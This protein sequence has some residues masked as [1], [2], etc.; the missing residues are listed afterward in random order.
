MIRK[1]FPFLLIAIFVGLQTRV[2]AQQTKF[3]TYTV[4]Y[5]AYR[6]AHTAYQKARNVYLQFGTLKAK[7][8]AE[9]ATKEMLILRSGTL[10]AYLDLLKERSAPETQ[11]NAPYLK[12]LDEE[13]SWQKTLLEQIKSTDGL[14][15]LVI[16]SKVLEDRYEKTTSKMIPLV[17]DLVN[18]SILRGHRETLESVLREY[19]GGDTVNGLDKR[20]ADA[21]SSLNKANQ[22]ISD[23][24]TL[25]AN[26]QNRS[27]DNLAGDINPL[28]KSAKSYYLQTANYL[29]EIGRGK[30]L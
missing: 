9:L 25:L 4:T 26:P 12:I 17:I 29:I 21:E 16:V 10:I 20:I 18:F 27:L 1:L 13:I 23:A 7:S 22:A 11:A 24:E 2:S 30:N 14:D 15:N 28:Q 19:A 8:D 6:D 5:S 3:D